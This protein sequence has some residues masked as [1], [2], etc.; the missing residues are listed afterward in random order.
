MDEP[1]AQPHLNIRAV[2]DAA[3]Q[4]L[5]RHEFRDPDQFVELLTHFLAT[6]GRSAVMDLLEA[7]GPDTRSFWCSWPGNPPRQLRRACDRRAVLEV[8]EHRARTPWRKLPAFRTLEL[9]GAGL[10]PRGYVARGCGAGSAPC[11]PRP[12]AAEFVPSGGIGLRLAMCNPPLQLLP[13]AIASTVKAQLRR[14]R[15]H[16]LGGAMAKHFHLLPTTPSVT[17]GIAARR[18]RRRWISSPMKV[19]DGPSAPSW[20]STMRPRFLGGGHAFESPPCRRP[21]TP[22]TDSRKG[23]RSSGRPRHGARAYHHPPARQSLVLAAKGGLSINAGEL[24]LVLKSDR[25]L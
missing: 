10:F 7:P 5:D 21:R 4:A 8:F 18:N 1:L 24:A 20:S 15:A 12:W 19:P 25:R 6:A 2:A 22:Q 17:P 16:G 13:D 23:A 14:K 11:V 9:V 3:R